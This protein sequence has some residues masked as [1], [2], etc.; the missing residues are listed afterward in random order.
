MHVWIVSLFT[1]HTGCL[2]E[3]GKVPEG[4]GIR[5]ETEGKNAED[6]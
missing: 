6:S 2:T 1:T 5:R 4:Q 3:T